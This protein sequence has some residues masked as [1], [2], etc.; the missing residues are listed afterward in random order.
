MLKF[1]SSMD[2]GVSGGK[3]DNVGRRAASSTSPTSRATFAR[4]NVIVP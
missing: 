2:E 3:E 4:K 1:S